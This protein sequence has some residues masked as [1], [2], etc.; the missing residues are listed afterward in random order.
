MDLATSTEIGFTCKTQIRVQ[1]I[2]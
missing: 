2:I 1:N